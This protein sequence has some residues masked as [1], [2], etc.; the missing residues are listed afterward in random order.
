MPATLSAKSL[1][2]NELTPLAKEIRRLAD[3]ANTEKREF[4]AE[5]KLAWEKVNKDYDACRARVD[6]LERADTIDTYMDAPI[7][8]RTVGKGDTQPPKSKRAATPGKIDEEVH[9][10]ALQAW[11]RR[12]L[13][14]PLLKRHEKAVELCKKASRHRRYQITPESRW[15][16][17]PLVRDYGKVRRMAAPLLAEHR[18]LSALGNTSG[19]Y[20]IPEGFVNSL[21]VAQLAYGNVRQVADVMRTETGQDLPW[22]S[23]ND[24]TNKGALLSENTQLTQTIDPS[25][26]QVVFHAYKAT[27]RLVLVPAEL[28]EDSAFELVKYLGDAFGI[29]FGRLESDV[30]TTGQGAS[31]PTGIVT[32][33]TLGVTAASDT[34]IAADEIYSLKHSV[35]PAYRNGAGWM[36]HDQT[37]LFIKKLKDGIGRY[38]WQSGLA[39]GAPDTLDGD[40]ITINQSMQ[41]IG[42]TLFKS[43]LYGQFSKYKIRDAGPVRMRHLVERYADYDQE[44]FIAF[45]RIDGN[46]LDAGTHP[47][48]YLQHP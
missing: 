29:R 40:K 5:E 8:D 44:G 28:L 37:L 36:M 41:Q 2:E 43:L 47:V 33:A 26:G 10:L 21:E 35:D 27:S 14:K 17:V 20:T 31:G 38:L 6:V 18:T 42:T 4:T 15:V 22:P 1:R 3:L 30:F 25:F 45:K 19:A 48:K 39:N 13:G 11:C 34:A 23:V 16:Q 24:T 46:L 7:G 12:Q 32:A 9:A